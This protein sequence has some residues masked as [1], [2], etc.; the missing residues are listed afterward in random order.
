[1]R[2]IVF[3]NHLHAGA[4]VLRNLV[5][6]GTFH[7]TQTYV[8]VPQA[9]SCTP[10]SLTVEFESFL[11]Q[12]SIKKCVVGFGKEQISR[13]RIVPLLHS[14]ERQYGTCGAL[15]ITDTTFTTNLNFENGLAG[16]IVI[17][18]ADVA[19]FKPSGFIRP[20]PRVGHE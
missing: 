10:V 3:L 20:D 9:I 1:M 14:A 4:A 5:D 12:D 2:R 15:A 17:D 6:V 13:L 19:V 16:G 8:C 18:D 11:F 7:Q